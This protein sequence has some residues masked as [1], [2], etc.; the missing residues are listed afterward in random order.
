MESSTFTF[1]RR[2]GSAEVNPSRNFRRVRGRIRFVPSGPAPPDSEPRSLRSS[3]K[4]CA[5]KTNEKSC[6]GSDTT[7]LDKKKNHHRDSRREERCSTCDIMLDQARSAQGKSDPRLSAT[8]ALRWSRQIEHDIT[9]GTLFFSPR[10]SRMVLFL[11]RVVVSE[12][13]AAVSSLNLVIGASLSEPLSYVLTWTF[14]IRD[15]NPGNFRK[16]L[17]FVLFVNSW[18]ILKLIAY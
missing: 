1:C 12:P 17:I 6:L 9:R 18:N 7:T 14:V 11:A 8:F 15:N 2:C 10:I 5:A 4:K 3:S 13:P 16:R